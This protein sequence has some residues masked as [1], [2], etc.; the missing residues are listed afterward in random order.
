VGKKIKEEGEAKKE[1]GRSK[2][3]SRG[4]GQRR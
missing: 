2:E 3:R 1:I 4:K